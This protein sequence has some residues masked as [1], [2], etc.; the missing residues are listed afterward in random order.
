ML[1]AEASDCREVRNIINTSQA[2]GYEQFKHDQTFE[3]L[4]NDYL[5][6]LLEKFKPTRAYISQFDSN[7]YQILYSEDN[8]PFMIDFSLENS[9]GG[10]LATDVHFPEYNTRADD[11]LLRTIEGAIVV[12][13]SRNPLVL[14]PR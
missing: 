12:E 5:N 4:S 7:R 1:K 8:M 9:S 13:L 11:M 3:D 10:C 14:I 2:R 6:L